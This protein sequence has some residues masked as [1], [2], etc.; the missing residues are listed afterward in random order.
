MEKRFILL[1]LLASIFQVFKLSHQNE[2]LLV[3]PSNPDSN[4]DDDDG[5]DGGGGALG[6]YL[7]RVKY[8]NTAPDSKIQ[9][10]NA[11]DD[12]ETIESNLEYLADKI[13][14]IV[15]D[16]LDEKIKKKIQNLLKSDC[17]NNKRQDEDY[18]YVDSYFRGATKLSES[19]LT[20][21]KQ[22]IEE[23]KKRGDDDNDEHD[24][25]NKKFFKSFLPKLYVIFLIAIILSVFIDFSN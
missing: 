4:N 11:L 15:I 13:Y 7:S 12:D 23:K 25:N 17:N 6:D 1:I 21:N 18:D 2:Q 20:L 19:S 9:L 5:H 24:N 3:H 22:K 16:R 10:Q 8:G 14:G